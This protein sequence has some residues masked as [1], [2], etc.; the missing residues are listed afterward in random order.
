MVLLLGANSVQATP[1]VITTGDGGTVAKI[2]LNLEVNG[3]TYMV[4]FKP[5]SAD[6]IYGA[7]PRTFD[8]DN[9]ADA[10]AANLAVIAA[11]NAHPPKELLTAGGAVRNSERYSIGYAS[12]DG[13]VSTVQG[14][15][16]NPTVSDWADA[17]VSSAMGDHEIIYA[18][19]TTDLPTGNLPPVADAGGPYTGEADVAVTFDGSGS[20][21]PDG[22]LM[23]GSIADWSW[24]FGDAGTATGEMAS[25]TYVTEGIFNVTLTVTDALGVSDSDGAEAT[26][27][28]VAQPPLADAGGPYEGVAGTPVEFDGSA[29]MS[30]N[31]N[32][33]IDV[34]T[35]DWG[36]GNIPSAEGPM[37]SH[38]YEADGVYEVILTVEDNNGATDDD[39]TDVLIGPVGQPPVADAGGPYTGAV[40][41]TIEFDG[42]SSTDADGD[43]T[44]TIYTWDFGDDI[45]G[46]GQTTSHAYSTSGVFT[47]SLT[48]EDDVGA[49]DTVDTTATTSNG[50]L[51]PVANPGGTYEGDADAPVSFDGS[52]SDDPDGTIASHTW[53]FGDGTSGSGETTTHTYSAEGTYTVTLTVA[54]DASA[55][56]SAVTAAEIGPAAAPPPPPPPPPPPAED[57]GGC[58]IATAAYGSY[59]E[60]EVRLLRDFRD[61]RLLTNAPGQAF[62]RLY[63]RTSPPIADIIAENAALR[64]VT[65]VAL[66]PLVYSV[67]YPVPAALLFF[68]VIIAP[69]SQKIRKRRMLA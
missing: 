46:S 5:D 11:L 50:N 53:D 21:D 56:D 68:L 37:P 47:V 20:D 54:D 57:S 59:L 67:K 58:F 55:L 6:E 62:V 31:A 28:L 49:T 45:S 63:Y 19:F 65:R 23:T 61:N 43:D 41:A 27:G 33:T 60:P 17:G 38:P 9:E 13:S 69:I 36:D 35:W 2:I 18:D 40:G 30:P 48:V 64:F 8:F 15:Y 52:G 7:E 14:R 3:V 4:V 10:Q 51:P 24:D 1:V 26:I 16:N 22:T 66:T 12:A 42:T 34:Y 25:H 44:I 39:R 32:G 29:S